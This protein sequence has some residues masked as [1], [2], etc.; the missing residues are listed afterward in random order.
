[1]TKKLFILGIFATAFLSLSLAH[2]A[3]DPP[4]IKVE[5]NE[6]KYLPPEMY[7]TWSIKAT[8]LSTDAP[9]DMYSP[10]GTELWTLGEDHGV[11][12]IKNII[13]NAQASITVDQVEGNTAT[14]HHLAQIPSREM[15]IMEIPTVTVEGDKLSGINQQR[16]VFFRRGK[17]IADYSLKIKVEGT[18]LAGGQVTF[19]APQ[20]EPDIEIAPIEVQK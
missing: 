5:V 13:T 18:R 16:V 14:F 2:A 1:M 9:A 4:V 7:G 8:I 17:K 15:K 20:A 10:E 19:G 11:V 3:N 6:S 12:F